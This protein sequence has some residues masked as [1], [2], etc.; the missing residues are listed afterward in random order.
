[1]CL[2][3]LLC[4]GTL[5]KPQTTVSSDC[6]STRLMRNSAW[7]NESW[8]FTLASFSTELASTPRWCQFLAPVMAA[9]CC[10]GRRFPCELLSLHKQSLLIDWDGEGKERCRGGGGGGSGAHGVGGRGREDV[11]MTEPSR[12]SRMSDLAG[13]CP[14]W[15]LAQGT[16]TTR[17][18]KGFF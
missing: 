4:R 3:V 18:R 5:R 9:M 15:A 13:K 1:M 17:E 8:C 16:K 10:N 14:V 2:C 6:Q 7:F 11:R 12:Q